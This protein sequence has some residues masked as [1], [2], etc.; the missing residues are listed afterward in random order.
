MSR[1]II[2]IGRIVGFDDRAP[3][4]YE[5][6]AMNCDRHV[7][8]AFILIAGNKI[9]RVGT[10]RQL[11]S[12]TDIR[13]DCE[14][15]IIDARKGWVFP[16]F[17]DSHTH[18]VYARSREQE[19]EDRIKGLT[20]EQI[21]ANGGGILNSAK[22]LSH[23]AENELYDAAM[24]RIHEVTA[25]GTGAIE[26]KSGYGLDV[27]SELKMLRVI[28][29]IKETAP[30]IVRSTFLGAHAV[31]EIYRNNRRGYVDLI[32]HEMIPAVGTEKLA[33]F[34]DV[35]CDRGFFTVEDTDRILDCAAKYGMKPKIHADELA[36]SGGTMVGIKHN[37][38]S[39][40]HL[41]RID[42]ESMQKLSESKTMPT[43]LPGAS[44]FLGMPYAPARKMID[45]G[46]SVAIASD[47]NPG[48]SPSGDMRFMM[49][50]GCIKMRLT[51][52]ESLYACTLNGASAMGVEDLI[53]SITPGKHANFFITEPLPSLAYITYA[54][55]TPV[56]RTVFLNGVPI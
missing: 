47:Y 40:D 53:G 9:K 56:I 27:E 11:E 29:R 49:A 1:L 6:D 15:D 19:F 43:V 30:L 24:Q 50:L 48:S 13:K 44:F 52:W 12:D 16:S 55:T 39:V 28:G 2:N 54:Y 23:T 45:K 3:R 21:A 26:I 34:V 4:R 14:G 22:V 8:E 36:S 51:P 10:M 5:G 32:C 35:F 41:E 17:C 42:E 37:A 46:M 33:D 38:L 7:D 20:Y 25:K 31:P 18:I